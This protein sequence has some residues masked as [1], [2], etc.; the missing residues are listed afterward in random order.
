MPAE[1][2]VL[3]LFAGTR[4]FLDRY[5]VSAVAEYERRMFE[6]VETKY[7]AILKELRELKDIS[8]D[9]DARIKEALTEFASIFSPDA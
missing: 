7:P 8:S 2:E 4:G 9:L 3:R 1:K 6:F 5:P